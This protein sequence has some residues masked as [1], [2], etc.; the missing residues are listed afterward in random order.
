MLVRKRPCE[1]GLGVPAV[2][3]EVDFDIG[4]PGT[5]VGSQGDV[6]GLEHVDN[7]L[8][9]NFVIPQLHLHGRQTSKEKPSSS[10]KPAEG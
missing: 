7:Q 2:R 5:P 10:W 6:H 9:A 3:E 4:A 1:G 8:M